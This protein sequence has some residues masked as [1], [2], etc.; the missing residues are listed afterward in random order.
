MQYLGLHPFVFRNQAARA[1]EYVQAA[2]SLWET[3][4][5]PTGSSTA[6]TTSSAAASASA[7]AAASAPAALPAPAPSL[8]QRFAAPAAYAL[9]SAIVA[10]GLGA[11][12]ARRT[13]IVD[14]AGWVQGHLRYVSHL[15]SEPEMRARLDGVLR[16]CDELG[17]SF[18]TYVSLPA[19]LRG[20]ARVAL[21]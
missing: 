5:T 12:Y 3:F 8:W 4:G 6:A 17:V 10:G 11:A 20:K 21:T 14:G 18:R 7:F 13:D 2:W 19:Q 15:W 16:V 9:G 1:T